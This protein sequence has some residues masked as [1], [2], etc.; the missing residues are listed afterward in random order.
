MLKGKTLT[1]SVQ[2]LSKFAEV[3]DIQFAGKTT[4]NISDLRNLLL[5]SIQYIITV[6]T[7][8]LANK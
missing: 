6:I 3:A 2:Y 1:D 8:R 7:A 4:W 5:K